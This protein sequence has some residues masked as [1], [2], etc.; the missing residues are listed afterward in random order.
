DNRETLGT[1][2]DKLAGV[3]QALT[4]SLDDIKQLLHVAPTTFQN[5]V[6]IY[7]PAQGAGSG[8][9][10]VNNFA[11][12]ITFICGAIQAASRM[13]AEHSAKLCVQYLA[14]I[15]KNRQYNFPPIGQNLFV[16]ASA[17]PNELT[18][19]EDWLRPDYIPPQQP[20][21]VP[22]PS[23]LAAPPAPASGAPATPDGAPSPAANTPPLPAEAVVSTNPSD[24]LSGIMV[25]GGG[26]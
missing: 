24:G 14:P 2:S 22:P 13:G 25:H 10:A 18:Y 8:V 1:T 9:A 26:S 17:R 19:S 21:D 6:N 15:I 23:A 16:T 12:P 5:Y 20:V 4:D 11:D 3:T 7:Q